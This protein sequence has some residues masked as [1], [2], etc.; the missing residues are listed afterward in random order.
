MRRMAL[1]LGSLALFVSSQASA[2]L[3]CGDRAEVLQHLSEKY[4]EAPVALGL[5]SSG[6]VL[7]VLSSS[8]SGSWTI[9]ITMPNGTSC[10]VAAGE[11]WQALP[12]TA[13]LGRAS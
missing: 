5:S 8:V 1:V 9:L 13:Q 3:A 6:G 2:Q 10:M 12:Q 4:Q 7:E 11:N